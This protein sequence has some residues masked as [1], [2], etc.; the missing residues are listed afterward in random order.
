VYEFKPGDRVAAFHVMRAPHGSFAEYALA[1]DWTTFHIPKSVS[2]ESAATI[3]LAALTA[4]IGLYADIQVPNPFDPKKPKEGEKVPI[5]IYGAGSAVGAFG[6]QLA[7]LSGLKPIIGVA[8]ASGANFAKG[9]VDHVVDYR[10]GEDA[11][12]QGIEDVLKKEGLPPKLTYVLD[13]ISENGSFEAIA[14]V[15]DPENGRVSHVLPPAKY[16]KAGENFKYPGN[17]QA[18]QT[19]VGQAHDSQK[20][21]AFLYVRY[22]AQLLEEGRFKTHPYEVIPGGLGGVQQGLQNLKEGKASGVKYVYRIEETGGVK[23]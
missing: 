19:S 5:L 17:A 2:F 23:V 3:P 8:G 9:L 16:A 18:I 21:L 20:D 1:P 10:Q 6:A 14:Q 13:A 15:V 12:V 4:V 7:R 22:I 11:L